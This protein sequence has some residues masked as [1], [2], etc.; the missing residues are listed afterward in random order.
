VEIQV[1]Q[2]ANLVVPQTI[3]VKLGKKIQGVVNEKI[4]HRLFEE[5]KAQTASMRLIREVQASIVIAS[6]LPVPEEYRLTVFR[7]SSE[8]SESAAV[9][10]HNVTHN[11]NPIKMEQVHH[12]LQLRITAADRVQSKR[13][14]SFLREETIDCLQIRS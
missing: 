1:Q 9:V 4:A 5:G 8:S 6:L 10:V 7:N 3:D 2:H 11:R 13:T 12:H 14:V